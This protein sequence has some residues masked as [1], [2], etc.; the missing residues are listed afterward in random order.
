M[1]KVTRHI[2]ERL[3]QPGLL[4]T[5][6]GSLSPS[7]LSSVLLDVF[8]QLVARETPASLLRKYS[9]NRFAQPAGINVIR[10]REEQLAAYRLLQ[11]AGFEPLELPP[12]T[13]LGA[14]AVVAPVD[15]Q[16]IISA[17]RHTEVLADPTNAIAL[18]YAQQKKAGALPGG[19]RR[20]CSITRVLRAQAL[21][22]PAYTAHFSVCS[23]VSL[24]NATAGHSFEVNALCEHVAAQE[25]VLQQVY[26]QGP[27]RLELIPQ[28]GHTAEHPLFKAIQQ[29]WPFNIPVT[30]RE[31]DHTKRYYTGLQFKVVVDIQGQPLEIGDGGLVNWT[32]Q[33]L[34]DKSERMLI[35]GLGTQLLHQLNAR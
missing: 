19:L 26:V 20:Y 35:S 28:Q 18:Y 2:L 8:Q 9:S 22:N 6:S 16:K 30:I 29:Q 10:D 21:S 14:C 25:A 15:Q 3:R 12:V 5:L 1:D 24:G 34:S 7:E 17:L 13:E 33:L 32:Q 27:V 31:P 23:L 4:E 11:N